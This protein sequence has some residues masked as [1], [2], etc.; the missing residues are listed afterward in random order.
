MSLSSR[1][2]LK[3][4]WTLEPSPAVVCRQLGILIPSCSDRMNTVGIVH[5]RLLWRDTGG[6]A[7][8]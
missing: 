1:D 4:V 7:Q 5:G 6:F 3:H 8:Q 2:S